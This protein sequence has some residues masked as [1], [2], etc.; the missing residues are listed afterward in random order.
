LGNFPKLSAGL[1]TYAT[2]M[3]S[4]VFPR[5]VPQKVLGRAL[6]GGSGVP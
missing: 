3:L 4:P 6:P 1:E 5:D 2:H